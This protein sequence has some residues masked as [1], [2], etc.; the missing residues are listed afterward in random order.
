[1]F[2]STYS[3]PEFVS[4]HGWQ[5]HLVRSHFMQIAI[6]AANSGLDPFHL[7]WEAQRCNGDH[8]NESPARIRYNCG[9]QTRFSPGRRI[10]SPDTFVALYSDCRSE[11]VCDG[12]EGVVRMAEGER[13]FA[14]VL[15]IEYDSCGREKDRRYYYMQAYRSLSMAEYD[16]LNFVD[17]AWKHAWMTRSNRIAV[18]ER[19]LQIW[20]S[21]PKTRVP[22]VARRSLHKVIDQMKSQFGQGKDFFTKK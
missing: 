21:L 18:D 6:G 13:L 15:Q 12:E 14:L 8:R 22:G 7:D 11:W 17:S 16:G 2:D 19:G 20:H 1:M 3:I 4:E 10:P 5:I 9:W